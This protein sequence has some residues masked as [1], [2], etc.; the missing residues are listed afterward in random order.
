MATRLGSDD[1]LQIGAILTR[2]REREGL[3]LPEVEEKTKIRV[4][5][6]RA[7][8]DEDWEVLPAPAYARGFLRAYAELLGLDAE[9][10]VDE[11]RARY[12][13]QTG[14][15]E[16]PEPVLRRRSGFDASKG[17]LRV[18][19]VLAAGLIVL[20]IALAI[21]ILTGAA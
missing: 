4:R 11:F 8:E 5:Y 3:D 7:L 1:P 20:V 10:L 14:T 17:G 13:S 9:L 6:L 2:T 16:L 19:W 18:G 21:L 15:F 12:E